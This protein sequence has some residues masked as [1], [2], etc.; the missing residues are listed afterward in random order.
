MAGVSACA[1]HGADGAT[2]ERDA[3]LREQVRQAGK[4][5]R[6]LHVSEADADDI[7]QD[8]ALALLES[9]EPVQ[10]YSSW[11]RKTAVNRKLRLLRTVKRSKEFEPRI[12]AHIEQNGSPFPAPDV[13][14]ERKLTLERLVQKVKPGRREVAARGLA[15]HDTQQIAAE[16][17][18]PVNTVKSQ[19][20]RAKKDIGVM[21]AVLKL[22][23][24]F[25]L[26]L[27][28]RG[29]RGP[30]ATTGARRG[31]PL[32]AVCAAL[33]MVVTAHVALVLGHERDVRAAEEAS[34]HESVA[35]QDYRFAPVLQ[36]NA[37]R[38]MEH[39]APPGSRRA[40]IASPREKSQDRGYLDHGLTMAQQGFLAAAAEA[41]R[42]YDADYPHNPSGGQRARLVAMLARTKSP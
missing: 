25:W 13:E 32:L 19:W 9:D 28:S 23:A 1:T 16:L 24:V 27:V 29:R 17:K 33:P 40:G 2:A 7:M 22:L 38:E 11:F 10:S 39:A 34:V 37:E 21:A 30:S 3:F 15:G 41:L 35:G 31:A 42:L 6:A 12:L 26:W 8:S 20:D 18:M 36:T 4:L 5:A 14:V